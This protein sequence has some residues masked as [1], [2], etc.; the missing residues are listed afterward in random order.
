M[1]KDKATSMSEKDVNAAKDAGVAAAMAA[2][3]AKLNEVL[4]SEWGAT[5]EAKA[6]AAELFRRWYRPKAG[7]GVLYVIPL[8]RSSD[9]SDLFEQ[10]NKFKN[11][12][13]REL[14]MWALMV[15]SPAAAADQVVFEGKKPVDVAPKDVVYTFERPALAG[16]FL[17]A[18]NGGQ[19]IG[20]TA[21]PGKKTIES[22]K[23]GE[24]NAWDWSECKEIDLPGGRPAK[25]IDALNEKRGKHSL[26][27]LDRALAEAARYN[28]LPVAQAAE[29]IDTTGEVVEG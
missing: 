27:S 10:N 9:C 11:Q 8:A 29:V 17:K 26:P 13:P 15:I 22:A 4:S 6:K 3:Q 14:F 21:A 16:L 2:E 18:L 1:A 19:I 20:I 28:A 12:G 7:Q 25:L 23:F 24:V 5:G